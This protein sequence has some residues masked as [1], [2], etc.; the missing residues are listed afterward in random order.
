VTYK[1]QGALDGIPECPASH[2]S[3]MATEAYRYVFT[4]NVRGSFLP[5]LELN[6]KRALKFTD[7]QRCSGW[8]LSLFV[9]ARTARANFEALRRTNP[10]IHKALGDAIAHGVITQQDGLCCAADEVGHFDLHEFANTEISS[11]FSVVETLV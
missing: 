6:P 3:Q 11:R 10:K 9:S 7:L 5:V 1:Y 4:S 2:F 8:A